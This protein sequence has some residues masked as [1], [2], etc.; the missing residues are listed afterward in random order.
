MG[1]Y[2]SDQPPKASKG[3]IITAFILLSMIAVLVVWG[4][5]TV[6]SHLMGEYDN[7]PRE[8]IDSDDPTS[9][10]FDRPSCVQWLKENAKWNT[11]QEDFKWNDER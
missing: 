8:C 3:A 9:I 6:S 5:I 4:I 1:R 10:Y 2:D 11:K 7:P